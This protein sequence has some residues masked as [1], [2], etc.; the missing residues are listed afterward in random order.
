MVRVIVQSDGSIDGR[1]RGS[2]NKSLRKNTLIPRRS[3]LARFVSANLVAASFVVLS[4]AICCAQEGPANEPMS[5]SPKVEIAPRPVAPRPPPRTTSPAP[6]GNAQ[7]P[8]GAT[9]ISETYVDWTV[10]CSIENGAKLCL[11][12]QAQGNNQTRQPTFV[13]ELQP[14]KDG[15]TEGTILMP[16][17]MKLDAGGILKLDDKDLV[18]DARFSTCLPQGCLLTVSLPL[19]VTEAMK[20][21]SKLTVASLNQSKGE[22]VIFNVSLNGFAAAI[23]RLKQIGG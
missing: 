6:S 1:S 17:G 22:A 21:A 13:I 18:Q 4:A 14:P 5:L 19:S 12:S 9:T 10:T 7:L 2:V 16:L 3:G 8:N 15:K 20:K 23:E 11:L